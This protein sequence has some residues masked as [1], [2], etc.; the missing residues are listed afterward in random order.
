MYRKLFRALGFVAALAVPSGA[1]LLAGGPPVGASLPSTLTFASGSTLSIRIGTYTIQIDLATGGDGTDPRG[2]V[3]ASVTGAH[4]ANSTPFAA[5]GNTDTTV[6]R[7]PTGTIV[8]T[9]VSTHI[10]GLRFTTASGNSPQIRCET[11]ITG[12]QNCEINDAYSEGYT[13]ATGSLAATTTG[14]TS[15]THASTGSVTGATGACPATIVSYFDTYS[16]TATISGHVT[17][18]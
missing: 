11:S 4:F 3:A 2:S 14:S 18:S 9:L 6:M 7:F 13:G 12:L 8:G 15:R 10:V 5:P 17:V 1:A 16:A